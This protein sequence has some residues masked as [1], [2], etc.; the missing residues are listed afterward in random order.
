MIVRRWECPPHYCIK[1][2]LHFYLALVRVTSPHQ[3]IN[4]V[5]FIPQNELLQ[6]LNSG[7]AEQD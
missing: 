5:Y 1:A 2:H 7:G 6:M 3:F 4:A